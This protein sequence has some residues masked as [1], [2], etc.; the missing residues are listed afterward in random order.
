MSAKAA[1]GGGGAPAS[2]FTLAFSTDPDPP[3]NGPN[4]FV[5]D[6]RDA[7]GNAVTDAEV[8]VRLYMAPM[9]SMNMPAMRNETKLPHVGGG[10]SRGMGQVLTAGHWDV[11]I[12]VS[13]GGQQLGRKQLALAAR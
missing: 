12:V 13:R 11:T 4:T 5:V 2:R 6:V 7:D 10:V 3:R 9:P 1:A 8:D